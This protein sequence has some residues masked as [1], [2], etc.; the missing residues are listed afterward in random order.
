[1]LRLL[2]ALRDHPLCRRHLRRSW[3]GESLRPPRDHY[4]GAY[5][6]PPVETNQGSLPDANTRALQS[7]AHSLNEREDSTTQERGKVG[8]IGKVEER[9]VYYAGA[10]DNFH[11][12]LCSGVL[13]RTAF[14]SLRNI[15]SQGRSLMKTLQFPVNI[16]NR[17]AY[18]MAAWRPAERSLGTG[19]FP[20]TSEEQFGSYRPI[21]TPQYPPTAP[22]PALVPFT[23]RPKLLPKT[24]NPQ[25]TPIP[26]TSPHDPQEEADVPEVALPPSAE[27][28]CPLL[29]KARQPPRWAT[30]RYI[31][32]P[33]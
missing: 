8:S 20:Q 11:V 9:Y 25:G 30:R 18:G 26:A 23:W 3:L 32:R 6:D 12:T 29:Q 28:V 33:R 5:S 21:P 14:N 27:P 7:I 1:M 15:A 31:G 13:G 16:T 4:A 24:P 22:C 10:C 17:I 19:D 2:H